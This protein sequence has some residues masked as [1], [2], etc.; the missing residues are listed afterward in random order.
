MINI[1]HLLKIPL[2][3]QHDRLNHDH[4]DHDNLSLDHDHSHHDQNTGERVGAG[5]GDSYCD[6]EASMDDGSCYDQVI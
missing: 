3:L 6:S 1:N 2:S 4:N 5:D